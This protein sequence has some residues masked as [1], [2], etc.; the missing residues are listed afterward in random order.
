MTKRAETGLERMRGGG[1]ENE[2]EKKNLERG[3]SRRGRQVNVSRVP[4]RRVWA[5]TA[6]LLGIK[7]GRMAIRVCVRARVEL[8][9][10]GWVVFCRQDPTRWR[11]QCKV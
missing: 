7:V 1:R 4:R 2:G 11:A 5:C 6:S 8:G 10:L 3:R 9:W